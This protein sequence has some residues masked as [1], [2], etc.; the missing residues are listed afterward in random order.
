MTFFTNSALAFWQRR[1]VVA[2]TTLLLFLSGVAT[3]ASAQVVEPTFEI[4]PGVSEHDAGFSIEGIRLAQDFFVNRLQADISI[5][6]H[7]TVLP[8]ADEDAPSRIAVTD[9]DR[10]TV[11]TGSRGWEQTS[12]AER[13]AVIVH[14]YAHF[15]QYLLLREH[16]FDSPAWFDEGVA[17]FLSA[18]AMS[19]WGVIDRSEFDT[20]WGTILSLAT[21]EE[22]LSELEDWRVYQASDGAVYPLSYFAV[23]ALF[24]D[25]TDLSAIGTVYTLMGAGQSF[26]TAFT[27]AFGFSPDDHYARMAADLGA[28]PASSEI[29]N[30]ILVYEPIER[31]TPFEATNT[32][33][34]LIPG[35]QVIIE[36]LA[37]PASVCTVAFVNVASGATLVE[38]TTFADGTGD[39]YWFVTVPAE[40]PGTLVS[41]DM[42]CGGDP[43]ERVAVIAA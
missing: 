25:T 19:E 35:D 26:D 36:G 29:S 14:E 20:Y 5:P 39:V 43:V 12:P 41:I 24:P 2:V 16:N 9:E 18:V 7:V 33:V 40:T 13:Y 22:T 30:D 6:L 27:L 28:P 4:A 1:C 15:Y 37:L 11:Y 23:A 38:R 31:R 3:G 21:P 42:A 34:S 32:P 8:T 17:E 10:I